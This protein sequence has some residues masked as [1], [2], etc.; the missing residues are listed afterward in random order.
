MMD[1]SAARE[2]MVRQQLAGRGITNPRLLE[3]MR[4]VPRELFVPP[5]HREQ[6]YDDGP[7]PIGNG[8][9]ISQPYIVALMTELL[10]LAGAETVLEVGTGSGY[11]TAVLA[12]L[13]GRVFSL[14]TH[15]ELTA[16]AR[17]K[18]AQLGI[19]N[20]EIM[21]GDGSLGWPERAPFDAI[22]VTAAA[23]MMPMPLTQQLRPPGRIVIP[24]GSRK[25]QNLERWQCRGQAWHIE[26]LAPVRFVPLIG[27]CGW[28]E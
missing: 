7:L 1:F 10:E 17:E 22:L 6:A 16:A 21:A 18:L 20:V 9:T 23:P 19:E 13:A 5:E 11:Q 14:D 27:Q 12:R 24:V 8:Q 26:K 2:Q 3:A 4:E 15:A 28:S 25:D